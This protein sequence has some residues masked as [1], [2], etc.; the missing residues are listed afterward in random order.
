MHTGGIIGTFSVHCSIKKK[1][2]QL[3]LA[4]RMRLYFG[5]LMENKVLL[6]RQWEKMVDSVY[7]ASPKATKARAQ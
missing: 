5:I 4:I 2:V 1:C 7:K 6:S 3:E